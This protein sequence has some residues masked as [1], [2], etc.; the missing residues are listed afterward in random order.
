MKSSHE[1]PTVTHLLH[2]ES[3]YFSLRMDI[4]KQAVD[5][6]IL[7]SRREREG[8]VKPRSRAGGVESVL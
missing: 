5:G 4:L 6:E 1:I 2:L 7:R 8:K 3:I